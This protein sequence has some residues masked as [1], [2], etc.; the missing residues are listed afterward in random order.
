[1][2]H[3][4]WGWLVMIAGAAFAAG[5][6]KVPDGDWPMYNRDLAGTRY[7][8]L[9]QIN[10][11]NVA[12]LTKVWSYRFRTD[13]ERK[14]L[15][16]NLG[17]FSEVTPIV[18][19]GVMYMTAGRRVLALDPETGK[20][21]WRYEAKAQVS[22]RGVSYWAGD[23][24]S[25]P[26][27][28]GTTDLYMFAL[29]TKNGRLVPGFG[30]EGLVN[31][32]VPYDSPP[33][34]YK[35]MAIVGANNGEN[36]HGPP[37]DSRAYDV[38]TGKKLWDFHSIPRPGE[39]GHETWQGDDWKGR[40]GV[41]VWGFTMTV[42][43]RRGIIY[44]PFGGPSANY[45][46]GDRKG[47]NLYGNSVVAVDAATGK[48]KWYFQ[49]IH[50]DV[51]DYDMPPAPGLID[52]VQNGKTIPAL[53]QVGKMGY[54]FILDRVTGKPVFGVEE[55]PVPKSEVPGEETSPT[56]P[57]PLKPPELSKHNFK[58]EDI[59]T[60]EDTTPEHAKA[61]QEVVEKSGGV[62]NLGPYTTYPYRA[63]GAPPKSAV[64]YPGNIGSVNWGGTA[65]DPQ[66]GYVIVNTQE[67]GSI[68]WIEKQPEGSA[69]P[70]D[71]NSIYGGGPPPRF[72]AVVR[73]ARG[74]VDRDKTWPCQKPPW[75]HLI[76]VNASTGEFAWRVRL[77][78][79]DELPEGK[80]NTGRYSLGGPIATAAG[81]AFIGAT[82][83]HRFRAFDS[84]TGKELW[85]TRLDYSAVSV[86]M[87]YLGKNGKQYVAI[88][89]GGGQAIGGGDDH[90]NE[91]LIV[92]ALP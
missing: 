51:W 40:A 59:V 42:D 19:D 68:G 14:V 71:K 72:E 11:G 32:T 15:R 47:A 36:P 60:A 89:E 66:L 64:L 76:A 58:I 6:S 52:I 35:D 1:M 30:N 85:V 81:L 34:I 56:Q 74:L 12:K 55:R 37:G 27:I 41:N 7:S 28:L 78:V 39:P 63:P 16:G 18:I 88:A 79:T 53:A 54:M 49:T 29:D 4:R 84:K 61:C 9:T 87:T 70:Y 44:M 3:V 38:R 13:E 22:K 77:G 26:R 21:I 57:I 8:P 45:Y 25:P 5:Q 20:E 31:M 33:I 90:N 10:P 62:Y 75:G 17:A 82:N 69:V 86:P 80:K 46:G 24:D 2:K 83:D 67:P 50:H 73:D 23:K 91:S 65:T 43:E 92:F 48:M